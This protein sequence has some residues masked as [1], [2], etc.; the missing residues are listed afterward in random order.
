MKEAH[1]NINIS[2]THFAACSLAI[3]LAYSLD[4]GTAAANLLFSNTS[5]GI[6]WGSGNVIICRA[7]SAKAKVLLKNGMWKR[8]GLSTSGVH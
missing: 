6:S 8:S 7:R 4:A 5:A 1:Q 2:F 3:R